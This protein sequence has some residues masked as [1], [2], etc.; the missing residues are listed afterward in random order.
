MI[1]VTVLNAPLGQA[2]YH[3]ARIR[4]FFHI[5]I[6]EATKGLRFL[7]ITIVLINELEK[8]LRFLAITVGRALLGQATYPF[9]WIPICFSYSHQ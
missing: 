2:S 1:A 6:D 7:V 9:A 4:I 3:L 5:P 8:K